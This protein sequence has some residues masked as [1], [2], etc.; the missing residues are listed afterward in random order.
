MHPI[1]K[2]FIATSLFLTVFSHSCLIYAQLKSTPPLSPKA[3]KQAFFTLL[4]PLAQQANEEIRQERKQLLLLKN[5]PSLTVRQKK[6]LGTISKKYNEKPDSKQLFSALLKKVDTLPTAL[7]LAQAANESAWGTSRFAKQA[8]N[9]FGQWCYKKNCGIVPN[10]RNSG[11]RHEV[12][13]F[14]TPLA[15]I[16]S[17]LLNINTHPSYQ[18]LREI[19]LQLHKTNQEVT[20]VKLSAGLRNYSER[21]MA[22]VKDI[23]AIIKVNHLEKKA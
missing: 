13:K 16:Q 17:Y 7:L 21:R 23:V 6:W 4:R 10:K 5:S 12:K 22:Y 9:F 14:K 8:N 2:S 1:L 18:T 3:K 11:S 15:S 20:G 19:R